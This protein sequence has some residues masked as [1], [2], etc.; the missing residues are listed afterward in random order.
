MKRFCLLLLL[1]SLALGDRALAATWSRSS[2]FTNYMKQVTNPAPDP[3]S[4][5]T[6]YANYGL[7]SGGTTYYPYSTPYG[8]RIA[9]G[10]VPLE[11]ELTGGLAVADAETRL[12]TQLDA[13]AASLST[14]IP[15]YPGSP[16]FESLTT[17]LQEVLVDYGYTEGVGNIPA[18]LVAA[19]FSASPWKQITLDMLYV[20]V[21]DGLMQIVKNK[22]FYV[23]Y[24]KP[25]G[26]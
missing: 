5:S 17:D 22:A 9:Y 7:P 6:P 3:G 8:L 20:R 1:G 11:A 16:S 23:H 4:P 18:S 12:G 13:V 14:A 2:D 10:L 21:K 26:Y 25:K 24:L 19:V 15:T